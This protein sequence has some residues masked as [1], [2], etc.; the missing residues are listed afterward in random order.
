MKDDFHQGLFFHSI[1]TSIFCMV[2][3]VSIFEMHIMKIQKKKKN[4]EKEVIYFFERNSFFINSFFK[5]FILGGNNK[6]RRL[7]YQLLL[8]D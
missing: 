3:L 8:G 2:C 1:E 4:V 5:H 7:T 6:I